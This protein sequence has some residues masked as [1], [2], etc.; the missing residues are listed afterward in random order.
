MLPVPANSQSDFTGTYAVDG[1]LLA[2]GPCDG[3]INGK[4][5]SR[6]KAYPITEQGAA[7]TVD[8]KDDPAVHCVPDGLARINMRTLYEIQIR[9]DADAVKIKYQFGDVIRTIHLDGRPPPEDT[10]HSQHGYSVGKWQGDTLVIDTTHLAPSFFQY[11]GGPTSER[12]RIIERW[13]PSPNPGN[14]LM[15]MVL[16]DP[17]YYTK[18]FLLHR[19]EWIASD[20][21]E[22]E[23]WNCESAADVLLEDDPDLDAF[24]DE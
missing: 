16:D 24:F 20:T 21:G 2:V 1:P 17:V 19:R 3:H 10:P 14:L 12:A 6:C 23:P 9:H 5:E 18:P 22:L 4:W 8:G 15:D 7:F 11:S 13:W